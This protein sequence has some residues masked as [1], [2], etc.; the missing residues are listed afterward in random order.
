MQQRDKNT[1]A[2][3]ETIRRWY[4][5]TLVLEQ[6]T[7]T[8][9]FK[10]AS[11]SNTAGTDISGNLELCEWGIILNH[12][13]ALGAMVMELNVSAE[14]ISRLQRCIDDLVN[15]LACT[16]ERAR[17]RVRY[18]SS[19]FSRSSSSLLARQ[20]AGAWA[21]DCLSAVRSSRSIKAAC[22]PSQ[23]TGP[24]PPSRFLSLAPHRAPQ[25]RC[26]AR[27]YISIQSL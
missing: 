14:E 10:M 16:S 2:Q 6:A 27:W 18:Q 26:S 13:A 24:A 21:S 17:R 5:S 12:W 20:K 22:G 19:R 23:M 7:I 15:L 25:T 9:T 11:T 1:L 4:G 3:A 8:V